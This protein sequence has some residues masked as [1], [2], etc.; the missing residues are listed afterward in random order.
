MDRTV[1]LC[2]PPDKATPPGQNTLLKNIGAEGVMSTERQPILTA[3]SSEA[4]RTSKDTT[5]HEEEAAVR[6]GD[7]GTKT[8]EPTQIRA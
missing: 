8:G 5:R 2:Y 7:I 3:V 1:V 6:I 4:T